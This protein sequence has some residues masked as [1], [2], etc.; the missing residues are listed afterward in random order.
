MATRIC[1][2][3]TRREDDV[4]FRHTVVRFLLVGLVHR[5]RT[6]LG[7]YSYSP[8]LLRMAL[9]SGR[10]GRS[11]RLYCRNARH[12]FCATQIAV[13]RWNYFSDMSHTSVGIPQSGLNFQIGTLPASARPHWRSDEAAC[14]RTVE[15]EHMLETPSSSAAKGGILPTPFRHGSPECKQASQRR[16]HRQRLPIFEPTHFLGTNTSTDNNLHP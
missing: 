8:S 16:S 4:L 2:P 5:I 1:S 6:V 13:G 7:H 14:L 10:T 3:R 9:G 11:S 15:V 12:L